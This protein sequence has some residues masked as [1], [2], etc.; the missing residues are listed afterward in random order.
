M[1]NLISLDELPSI[2]DERKEE[3]SNVLFERLVVAIEADEQIKLA[4]DDQVDAISNELKDLR[5]K[6]FDEMVVQNNSD[7]IQL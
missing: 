2:I 6:Q 4:F 5:Q 1:T 7:Q 3:L